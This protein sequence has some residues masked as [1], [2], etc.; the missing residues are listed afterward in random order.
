MALQ[1]NQSPSAYHGIFSC[2]I[3]TVPFLLSWYSQS[4]PACLT[5]VWGM[6]LF[7]ATS[8]ARNFSLF[9]LVCGAHPKAFIIITFVTKCM[10]PFQRRYRLLSV[11]TSQCVGC[12]NRV[13]A[14]CGCGQVAA[15]SPVRS[16]VTWSCHVSNVNNVNVQFSTSQLG[17]PSLFG[18]CDVVNVCRRLS[19]LI[20]ETSHSF[21]LSVKLS[22][23]DFHLTRILRRLPTSLL[24]WLSLWL[25]IHEC[26]EDE[27]PSTKTHLFRCVLTNPQFLPLANF[28]PS[29][30]PYL[31]YGLVIDTVSD[32]HVCGT[33][34]CMLM[35]SLNDDPNSSGKHRTAHFK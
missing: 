25:F 22:L 23:V 6:V 15:Q 7:W 17:P 12:Q 16:H 2:F 4:P 33:V 29:V 11:G 13:V 31:S 34:R 21:L 10:R 14:V 32:V 8:R 30:G 3:P 20:A 35:L 1:G 5:H 18:V 27:F 19:I 26:F 9:V 24:N 28:L